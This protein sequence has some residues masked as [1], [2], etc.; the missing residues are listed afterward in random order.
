MWHIHLVNIYL[1]VLQ[2]EVAD[3]Y[4][5]VTFYIYFALLLCQFFLSFKADTSSLMK[6]YSVD[7]EKRPLLDQKPNA[8]DKWVGKMCL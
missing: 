3:M 4:V 5:F 7:G 6:S 1:F 2:D 8:D